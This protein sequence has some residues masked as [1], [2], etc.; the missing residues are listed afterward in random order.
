MFRPRFSPLAALAGLILIFTSCERHRVGEM[1]ELQSEHL[2]PL[3]H[4]G[5]EATAAAPAPH[6]SPTPANFFPNQKP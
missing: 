2:D 6:V 4:H 5:E 1:P 3:G